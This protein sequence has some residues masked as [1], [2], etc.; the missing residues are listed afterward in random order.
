MP[1]VMMKK[2]NDILGCAVM[3]AVCACSGD[4]EVGQYG[5]DGGLSLVL[6]VGATRAAMSSGE[7]LSSS[8]VSIY[9]ADFSGLVRQYR[10]SDMPSVVYLPADSY[11]IDVTAGEAAKSSPSVASWDQKSYAGS[12]DFEITAG[13][14][15]TVQV[16]AGVS[17]VVT[18][19]E[20]DSSIA[21]N[22]KSGYTFSIGTDLS[23]AS[24]R[25]VYDSSKSGKEGYF[26]V[27]G[28]EPSLYW[29]FSGVLTNDNTK[30]EK[31]G[32][33]KNVEPGKLYRMSP[34]YTVHDGEMS[35][36]LMVDYD[37]E[38]IEDIVVFEPVSTGL[39]ASKVSEIWAGHATIHADVD[40][41]EYSDPSKIKFAF[42]ADG[43]TWTEIPSTRVSEGVYTGLMTGLTGSTAYTYKLVID[44]QDIG[45]SMT[46]TTDVA[47]QL[48]NS[49]FETTSNTE[50]NKFTS[51]YDP[52]SSDPL[53]KA[54][55]WDS[56][57]VASA[58]YG[59]VIC[60]SSTDVPSAITGTTK[61][62]MLES[63][64]ALVKFAAGNL[65]TGEFGGLDGL[66]GKVNFGRPFT[67]RPTAVRLWYKYK[68]NAV[69]EYTGS[70]FN[71]GDY[72]ICTIKVALGT[73]SNKTY[74]GTPSCPVQVNTGNAATLWDFSELPETIAYGDFEETGNGSAG[75]WHQLTIKLNYNNLTLMPTHIIVSAA[76]SK[77]GDYFAGAPGSALWI[78]NV[79]LVYE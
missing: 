61:S 68:G 27:S 45:T 2:L 65:F 70:K 76:A 72:D 52:S 47:T 37:V 13:E 6:N 18:D 60:A 12:K 16:A 33:I 17:N 35:V 40:E 64:N 79:E 3:F 67:A 54:K 9:M 49:G 43:V 39:S 63:Q 46:L 71:K 36:D 23:D 4:A 30:F 77:F 7:L 42:S 66:N 58:K 74:G 14:N 11:R 28:F 22:F 57:N 24:C 19:V 34:A 26:I 56:G 25:L 1:C 62:A 55:F 8:Q 69:S 53:L 78:D 21:G 50:S 31:S 20:F 75:S 5:T 51:F 29:N 38:I 32:E 10:Y 41:S 15:T 48:P 44:G 59:F 73:W